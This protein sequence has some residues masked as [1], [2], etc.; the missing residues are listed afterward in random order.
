MLRNYFLAIL[1]GAA[2]S[3][4]AYATF[5]VGKPISFYQIFSELGMNWKLAGGWID[6]LL[7]MSFTYLFA[8]AIVVPIA[9]LTYKRSPQLLNLTGAATVI[10]YIL[11]ILIAN[12]LSQVV[13]RPFN[14]F[15]FTTLYISDCIVIF[16]IVSFWA[17]FGYFLNQHLS[18]R[19]IGT[20][21]GAP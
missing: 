8:S 7:D 17:K 4:L 18:N 2:V 1:C 12:V 13:W 19:S 20:P 6:M 10:T 21:N 16:F 9:G 14:I 3:G 11:L 5:P 15:Y